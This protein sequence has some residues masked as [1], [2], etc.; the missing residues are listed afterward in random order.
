M[1]REIVFDNCHRITEN[2]I[3]SMIKSNPSL[4]TIKIA[5]CPEVTSQFWRILANHCSNLIELNVSRC[6]HIAQADN[7]FEAF[8]ES[9][10]RVE[11]LDFSQSRL[12]DSHIINLHAKTKASSK[13]EIPPNHPWLRLLGL[14]VK[15][16][17]LGNCKITDEGISHLV[18]QYLPNSVVNL[19][20]LSLR[21]C[22]RVTDDSLLALSESPIATGLQ[23]LDLSCC[24]KITD[25]GI[26]GLFS[27]PMSKILQ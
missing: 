7:H 4:T 10:T 23:H 8:A 22:E 26:N 13:S 6:A 1:L 16:I 17:D 3:L 24:Q 25:I 5:G 15:Y 20:H 14:R 21:N 12:D 2:G 9:C 11:K 27:K 19:T 18:R